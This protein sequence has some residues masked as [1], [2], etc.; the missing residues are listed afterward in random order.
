[1][2]RTLAPGP[3]LDEAAHESLNMPAFVGRHV[4]GELEPMGSAKLYEEA[5]LNGG[6]QIAAANAQSR[7]TGLRTAFRKA[8][9]DA[10]RRV[11]DDLGGC[12]SVG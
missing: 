8:P 7:L 9:L 1:M 10:L 5:V 11:L 6:L 2:S 3:G 12:S 4:V